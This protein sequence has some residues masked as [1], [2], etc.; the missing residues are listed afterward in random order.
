MTTIITRAS[1][2]SPLTST[3]MDNNLTNLNTDKIEVSEIGVSIQA[4]SS[5][6]DS[7]ATVA[8]TAAGLA[9]LD[10]INAAAQ[11]TTLGLGNVDN[12]S[13]ANKPISTATQTALN[14]KQDA[15]T[16]VTKDSATGMANIPA[17][18]SAQRPASP[19]FGAQRANST[20]GAME[21]W[22]G[23]AWAPIGGDNTAG[24]IAY[25]ART[26]APTGYLKAN[27]ALVSRT[28]YAALFA[29]IGTTFGAGDGSTT[30]NLPD[31]R[32]EF[33]RG[34]DDGRGVDSGRAIGSAQSGEIQSHAHYVGEP[35]YPIPS[36]GGWSLRAAGGTATAISSYT[37]GAETRPR[38]VAMLA[39]IKF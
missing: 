35:S 23:T 2:G 30:F 3:E 32:G 24:H 26:S 17:G 31:L 29:A 12:T 19:P 1:K 25:F 11:R 18:T 22:N 15:S 5:N 38:N 36:S 10:D 7:F 20:I 14:A 9:L 16:A 34:W 27:G 6:L 28:T 21:W 8:P 39:C 4:H 37:G 33:I 13:D